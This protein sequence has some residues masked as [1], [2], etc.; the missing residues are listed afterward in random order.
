MSKKYIIFIVF[1]MCLFFY[2]L[3]ATDT[4]EVGTFPIPLMVEDENNGIFIELFKEIA[5]RAKMNVKISV[6]PP[7]RT[8]KNFELQELDIIF[9]ALDVNFPADNMPIKSKELIYIKQDFV[10]TMKGSKLFKKIS[11]LEGK[12][13]GVTAGYPYVFEIILNKKITIDV[14]NSDELNTQKLVSGRIDA[15]IVEEKSGIKA[16]KETGTFDKIQYDPKRPISEQAVY[17]AFQNTKKGKDL[18]K[19]I[20]RILKAMKK[21]GTFAR[22]MAKT[23][24]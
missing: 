20:S 2:P 7:K 21:D 13:I 15:F 8:L 10:F 14:A 18:E 19:Q 12:K 11:E 1:G 4:I 17:Y 9:P 3:A 6:Y 16:F 24:K 22:I 23:N 5:K